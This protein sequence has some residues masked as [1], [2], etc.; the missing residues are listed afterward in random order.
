VTKG[1]AGDAINNGALDNAL[2]IAAMLEVARAFQAAPTRPKRSILFVAVTAEEKGLLGSD[3]L[4]HYPV[5]A[6][7]SVVANVNLDMPVLLGPLV[8]VVAMG[9]DRSSIGPAVARAA[10]TEQ[11]A[12][13]ADPSPE[14]AYFVRTDHYSFVRQGIPSVTINSGPGG[15]GLERARAFIKDHYHQPS[16]DLSRPIDWASAR[17]FVRV[18]YA[19]ARTIADADARPQLEQGRLFRHAVQGTDGALNRRR[20]RAQPGM[21]EP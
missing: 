1:R 13:V 15:G 14:E 12:L 10:S 19:I 4:A 6:A 17:K 5:V 2:G 7:R 21:G 3:Y 8:D 11:L 16:D 20:R 9:A 18:N